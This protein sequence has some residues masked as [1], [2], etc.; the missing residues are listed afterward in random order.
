LSDD[1]RELVL[2]HAVGLPSAT[3]ERF[4]RLSIDNPTPSRDVVR[5]GAPVFLATRDAWL[6]DYDPSA[7]GEASQAWAALPLISDDRLLGILT[8]SFAAPRPF[9]DADRAFF[10]AFAQQGAQALA[11][12]RLYEAER[13][14]R[15]EAAA[16]NQAKM[17]FLAAMSHE[18]R[19]PLN[20]IAG[21][22]QLIELGLRGPVTAQQHADLARIQ[23]NQRHLMALVEDVLTYAKLDAGRT[24]FRIADVVVDEVVSE[25]VGM[26][27][28]L[29]TGRALALEHAPCDDGVIVRADREKLRQILLNLVSNAMK[30][31][32]AGGRVWI[33]VEPGPEDA[34]IH[35]RDTGPGIADDQREHIFEAFVQLARTTTTPHD[36]VG[37][38]LAISRDLAVGM[39]GDLSVASAPGRGA[40]FT[41]TL[42]RPMP[43]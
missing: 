40:T 14:A 5:G 12:A 4:A 15:A 26:M 39:G 22:T 28:P 36:G 13:R 33:D 10:V 27:S 35:V 21:Y 2:L 11:R 42:P 37:L 34:R 19:T 17:H 1:G 30:F 18:L 20:A 6:A 24:E 43:A 9:D 31:T 8:L 38:G 29:A 32:P 16:A 23:S 25:V 41:L 3:M 7:I